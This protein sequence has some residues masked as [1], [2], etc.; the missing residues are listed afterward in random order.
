MRRE[1]LGGWSMIAG[2]VMG[3]TTMALHP[4]GGGHAAL[5]LAV[6]ALAIT[7]TPIAFYGGWVLR[8]GCPRPAR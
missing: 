1:T 8:A 4:T 3:L 5:A 7:S 2:A 6:H